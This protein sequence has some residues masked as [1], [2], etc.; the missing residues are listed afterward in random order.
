MYHFWFAF[1]RCLS[2]FLFFFFCFCF[3]FFLLFPLSGA[4]A[5]CLRLAC[6]NLA[7]ARPLASSQCATQWAHSGVHSGAPARAPT[8]PRRSWPRRLCAASGPTLRASSG[9][10]APA[11]FLVVL[12]GWG[13]GDTGGGW[14]RWVSCKR[15]GGR[16]SENSENPCT[17]RH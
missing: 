11:R 5:V 9:S 2:F 12:G 6:R 17:K 4:A 13:E 1:F 10:G 14:W 16:H 7:R 3:C 8:A 15:P